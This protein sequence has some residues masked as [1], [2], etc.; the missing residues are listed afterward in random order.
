MNQESVDV[1]AA[2][3]AAAS[4][5]AKASAATYGGSLT[6]IGGWLVSSQATALLGL[7]I[8][9]AGLAV[10]WTYRHREFKLRQRESA[11]VL[12]REGINAPNPL[13]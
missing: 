5:T 6:L 4:A 12:R 2:A 9:I 1:A 11:A 13:Q 3:A 8:A 7:L 10:Q